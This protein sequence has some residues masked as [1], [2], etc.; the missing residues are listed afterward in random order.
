MAVS[1]AER[2]RN[3]RKNNPDKVRAQK[4]RQKEKHPNAAKEYRERT[5]ERAAET[6]LEWQRKNKEKVQKSCKKWRE[7]NP[8]KNRA[9][10]LRYRASKLERTVNWDKELTLLV[11]QEAADLCLRKEKLTGQKWHVDHVI[12]LLGENVSG[13]HVWNNLSVLLATENISKHNKYVVQ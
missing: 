5:K 12:P 6:R 10:S 4:E 2:L 13:L 3:W 8:D 11:E 1:N 7:Q 9:K